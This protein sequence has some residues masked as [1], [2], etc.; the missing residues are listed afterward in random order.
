MNGWYNYLTD[1]EAIKPLAETRLLIC[2]T[3]PLN[4]DNICTSKLKAP[5]SYSFVYEK[6]NEYRLAGEMKSGCGC[7]LQKKV[8]SF[9]TQCPLNS[10]NE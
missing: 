2:S 3:C 1:N 9:D 6:L 7:P 4:V 8:M 5:V 10:W